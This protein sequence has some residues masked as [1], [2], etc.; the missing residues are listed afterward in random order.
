MILLW[1]G[2]HPA[3]RSGLDIEWGCGIHSA[4]QPGDGVLLSNHL[5][6]VSGRLEDC[7]D[8]ELGG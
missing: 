3:D 5:V 2:G 6:V 4:P 1:C 8:G 7:R